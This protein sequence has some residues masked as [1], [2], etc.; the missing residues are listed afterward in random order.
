MQMMTTA[1]VVHPNAE[2]PKTSVQRERQDAFREQAGSTSIKPRR[3]LIT[4][5]K[6][7]VGEIVEED[8]QAWT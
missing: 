6:D 2:R 7:A 3:T 4:T 8:A 5:Q 1:S